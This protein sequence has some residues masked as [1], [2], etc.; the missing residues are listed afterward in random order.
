MNYHDIL[1]KSCKLASY[2]RSYGIQVNDRIAVCSENNLEWPVVICGILFA[3]ATI[4]PLNPGYSQR[5]FEHTVNISKPKY[6]FVSLTTLKPVKNFVKKLS[7]SPVLIS[8]LDNPSADIASVNKLIANIPSSSVNDFQVTD[9]DIDQHIVSI[10]C[11]SGTTGLPKGV[12]LNDRNYLTSLQNML[13][14]SVNLAT[15]GQ[16][17]VCMLPC[18][19]SYSFTVL[20]MGLIAGSKVVVFPQFEEKAFLETVQKYRIEV[21]TLVPPL[22]VFLAKHPIVDKYD[23]SCVKIIW[24]GAA[25][26]SREVEEAVKKRLNNPE[27][28]QGYG[29]TETTLSVV[30]I[31]ENSNKPGSA[32]KLIAGVSGT[33]YKTLKK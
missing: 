5:E 3:G 25:P 10:L 7:W 31:P 8:M 13:E 1:E 9:V 23:L 16:V 12:M 27:I 29:M 21:L 28:R 4:C 17:L 2:L 30:K 24:C 18:F 22:M 33:K 11:S 19:H 15:E 20:L 6:I 14:T 32:G 26:L